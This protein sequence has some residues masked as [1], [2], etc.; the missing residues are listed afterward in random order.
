MFI[1]LG[2]YG[3]YAIC[4]YVQ[5]A[6]ILNPPIVPAVFTDI[7]SMLHWLTVSNILV[8]FASPAVGMNDAPGRR[9][10][11]AQSGAPSRCAE[12]VAKFVTEGYGII[13]LA[14]SL[15]LCNSLLTFSS[16]MAASTP[17]GTA[18]PST[19]LNFTF[20]PNPYPP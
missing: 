7:A 12:H 15:S 4:L 9:Q 6:A 14:T 16:K 13:N 18:A 19:L 17:S 8:C 2:R 10:T 1:C 20:Y 3:F 11:K 5:T